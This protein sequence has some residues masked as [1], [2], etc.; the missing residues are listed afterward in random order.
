MKVEEIRTDVSKA[1]VKEIGE[2][3]K[4]EADKD[5]KYVVLTG[6]K[7]AI[8][9]LVNGYSEYIEIL[10]ETEQGKIIKIKKGKQR[11]PYILEKCMITGPQ[12]ITILIL[13]GVNENII[14]EDLKKIFKMKNHELSHLLN[15]HFH[16][17][18][19]LKDIISVT[20]YGEFKIKKVNK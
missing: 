18:Q 10:K 17:S 19:R 5:I 14:E 20:E 9:E 11:L 8:K 2:I 13:F 6:E 7:D 16:T 1:I 12:E 3:M 4:E 15:I